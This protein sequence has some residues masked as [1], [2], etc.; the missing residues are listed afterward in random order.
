[1]DQ[2]LTPYFT[3][4]LEYSNK[5]R[6]PFDVP[7]HK[8][9]LMKNELIKVIGKKA[10]SMDVNAPDGLDNLN[11]PKGV[12]KDSQT[13][14]AKAF[15]ADRSFFITGGTTIGVLALIMSTVRAKEKII[16]PR[17]V[18]KSIISA[19][20]MSGAMPVFIEPVIDTT[21]GIANHMTLEAFK[22]T[23][24]DNLDAKAVFIINPTYFGVTGDLKSMVDYAHEHNM[25]VLVDEAHGSHMVF[26]DDLPMT[27][28]QAGAD[29]SATSIHKTSG[30]LTQSSAIFAKGNRIDYQ[31]LV[32]TIHM[33]QST[34]PS[35]LLLASLDVARK[36]MY[37]NAHDGLTKL[38]PLI[39]SA[40]EQLNSIDGIHALT[41]SYFK[42]LGAHGYDKTKIIVDVS[43]LS[44][45]GFEVYKLLSREYNIQIELA[46][47]NV[48]LCVLS[49]A[50]TK[51]HLDALV[52]AFKDLSKKYKKDKSAV[53]SYQPKGNFP[54]AHVR[55]R[56][57][58]HAPFKIVNYKDS[59]DQ[60]AAESVMIYPPGIPILIPGEIISQKLIED[61][62][63]YVA[64]GSTILSEAPK[65]FIKIVDKDNWSKRTDGE[66]E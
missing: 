21:F 60:I 66:G 29:L 22:R 44:L 8:M 33:V 9:G 7:G 63:Y 64:Q 3:A 23:V 17:N 25:I 27:A 49:I 6:I 59:V 2:K 61:L 50:T 10:F 43:G 51:K 39:D 38:F 47:A 54:E 14:L 56:S 12:I 36:Y 30:S 26:H 62:M 18:H 4:L 35:S 15:Q 41:E 57:A 13:L 31:R 20:I 58:Y 11:I 24:D 1:M 48:I 46:E 16:M 37:Y 45:T 5:N 32:A 65:G 52:K 28:M 42:D 53:K 34:S 40:N 19:L 55:P